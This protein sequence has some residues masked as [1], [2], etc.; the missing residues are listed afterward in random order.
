MVQRCQSVD[1]PG[2]GTT[3]GF[4]HTAMAVEAFSTGVGEARALF[5]AAAGRLDER[6]PEPV[7]ERLHQSPGALVGHAHPL[8]RLRDRAGLGNL[9][10]Q[11]RATWT[12]IEAVREG[13]T[14]MGETPG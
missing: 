12:D 14:K 9:L 8:G 5:L 2:D 11:I 4:L 7:I 1:E 13:Y 3:G 10:H 6:R